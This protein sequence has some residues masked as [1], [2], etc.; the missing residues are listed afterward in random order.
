MP[1]Q[2]S[3]VASPVPL[4]AQPRQHRLDLREELLCAL[5]RRAGAEARADRAAGVVD[6]DPGRRRL[7]ARHVPRVLV[8]RGRSTSRRCSRGSSQ[9]RLVNWTWSFE[10][11]PIPCSAIAVRL[12]RL[13]PACEMFDRAAEDRERERE[14][15]AVGGD[16]PRRRC[17]AGRSACSVAVAVQLDGDE[18]GA[19]RDLPGERVREPRRDLVVAAA[20]VVLL[21]RLAEDAE[22]GPA[23][24]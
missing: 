2:K 4:R 15:D 18:L 12:Q 3:T 9:W 20:H 10:F 8:A 19:E 24:W 17:P 14:H 6:E 16:R 13:K 1:S 7:R 21:V 22:A 23:R 5:L 11:V